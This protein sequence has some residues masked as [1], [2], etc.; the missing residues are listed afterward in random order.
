MV[1]YKLIKSKQR[2]SDHGEVYTPH[3]IVQEMLSL[4]PRNATKIESRYL[5]TSAGEGAFLIVILMQKLK[6]VFE[7]HSLLRE[8]EF[9]TLVALSN[10][11][12]L[13][14]LKDNVESIKIKLRLVIDSFFKIYEPENLSLHFFKSIDV[15][16]DANIIN[17]NALNFK[18]PLSDSKNELI[19]DES[20][21][22]VYSSDSA[23][24]SEWLIDYSSFSLQQIEYY[25]KDV[26]LEQ[27]QR[28]EMN[29]KDRKKNEGIVEQ[30]SF[31]SFDDE[32]IEQ[33]ELFDIDDVETY[34]TPVKPLHIHNWKKYND[35]YKSE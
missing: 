7:E 3:R 14:L 4:I 24:I 26:V 35:L 17:I 9:Y 15:I 27:Q 30:L 8:R 33:L 19:K 29:E 16:L 6:L 13:E 23:K 25:Y 22:I 2:V 12:G 5:E 20:G 11:Y 1:D 10:V 18:I 31:F 28:Y 21:E 34:I 32:N